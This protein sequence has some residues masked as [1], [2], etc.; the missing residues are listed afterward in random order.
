MFVLLLWGTYCVLVLFYRVLLVYF[1][2][3][4][5]LFWLPCGVLVAFVWLRIFMYCGF[6]LVF[7]IFVASYLWLSRNGFVYVM[8]CGV[9]VA[10]LW[11]IC[12]VLVAVLWCSFDVFVV[13]L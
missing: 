3:I 7:F 1:W 2:R 13:F 4:C 6:V 11:C 9:V 8:L 12:V 10:Y 5:V